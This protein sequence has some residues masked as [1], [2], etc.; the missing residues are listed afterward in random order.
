MSFHGGV[1][2][3]CM[4]NVYFTRGYPADLHENKIEMYLRGGGGPLDLYGNTII[5][6]GA[7]LGSAMP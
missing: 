5:L 7:P 1:L 3:I 2:G 4:R 6:Q